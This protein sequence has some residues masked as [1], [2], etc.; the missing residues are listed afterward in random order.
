M[1]PKTS[2]QSLDPKLQE[3]YNKVMGI[4][5]PSASPTPTTTVSTPNVTVSATQAPTV[6]PPP[7]MPASNP[8]TSSG[9]SAAA[10]EPVMPIIN[11]SPSPAP[12]VQTVQATIPVSGARVHIG[13][14]VTP[15]T[16]GFVAK[17]KKSG[18]KISPVILILGGVVF[19]LVYALIW[20]KVFNLQLPFLPQ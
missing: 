14:T 15:E 13:A 4:G 18:M 2:G 9:L 3:A 11:H 17:G 6:P 20:V 12:S 10:P 7:V 19:F 16:H 1:D 5:G 8:S